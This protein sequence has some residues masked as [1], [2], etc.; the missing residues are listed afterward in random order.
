MIE[1]WKSAGPRTPAMRK[2]LDDCAATL[3][4]ITT[5]KSQKI[6][7]M[8][9]RVFFE[10]WTPII[11]REI[12]KNLEVESVKAAVKIRDQVS[13]RFYNTDI[14]HYCNEISKINHG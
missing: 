6:E 7:D 11:N 4:L 13:D 3:L 1:S 12:G 9:L 14:S 10:K 5:Q 8:D 2:Y